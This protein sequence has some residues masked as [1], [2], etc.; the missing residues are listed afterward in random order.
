MP[1]TGIQSSTDDF[2]DP[3][4]SNRRALLADPGRGADPV[5]PRRGER[6]RGAPAP[7]LGRAQP[8][9]GRRPDRCRDLQDSL[10]P[11]PPAPKPRP[12]ARGRTR[13]RGEPD[14]GAS[15]GGVA[16]RGAA[17]HA[18]GPSLG[19]PQ[20]RGSARPGSAPRSTGCCTPR[21]SA[22]ASWPASRHR[23]RSCAIAGAR[24]S[25]P[26]SATRWGSPSSWPG[27]RCWPWS[28]RSGSCAA[29]ATRWPASSTRTSS[30]ARPSGAA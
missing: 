27:R 4:T 2:R 26:T 20:A 6:S 1:P 9:R 25:A 16:G 28:G 3:D 18:F 23:P 21:R 24:P 10:L 22:A 30:P 7:G 13:R 29:T 19:R 12:E 15:A 8:A 17:G 14:P 11:P 5:P